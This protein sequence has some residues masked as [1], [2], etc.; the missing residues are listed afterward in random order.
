M[1]EFKNFAGRYNTDWFSC[2]KPWFVSL[3]I[4]ILQ[5]GIKLNM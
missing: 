4:D 3:L 5:E 2:V 1:E